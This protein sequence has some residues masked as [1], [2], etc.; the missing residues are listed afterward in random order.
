MTA[1]RDDMPAGLETLPA[2]GPARENRRTAI[3]LHPFDP[4]SVR[5]VATPSGETIEQVVRRHVADPILRAHLVAELDGIEVARD[6]WATTPV[7]EGDFLLLRV[8]PSGDDGAKILRT[9]L[10]I[11][12]V[13]LATWVT[14]GAGGAMAAQSFWA[15]A[16]AATVMVVG[17]LAINA[18]IP[19]PQPD[20]SQPSLP[21]PTYSVDG[22]RNQ[23]L[24]YRPMP[25]LFGEHRVFPPL[26]G[27]P[28]QEIVG[29]DV[30]LRYLLNLGPMPLAYDVA[31]I[32]I[33]ETPISEY[34][35][36]EYEIR[37]TP[38]DP[39]ITL[40]RDDP[41]TEAVGTLLDGAGW[42]S[43]TSQTETTELVAVFAFPQGLGQVDD[44]GRNKALSAS[45]EMRYRPTGSSEPWVYYRPTA[46]QGNSAAAA[47]GRD[48]LSWFVA[49]PDLVDWAGNMPGGTASGSH[50]VTRSD[51]GKPFRVALRAA[52]PKG[53]YDVE[54]RRVDTAQGDGKQKFDRVEWG[55]LRSI[56]A[57][58]PMPLTGYAYMAVYVKA[59]DQ[60]SGVVD[61]IN[62][63]LK[64]KAPTL[65]AAIANAAE[66][67]LSLVAASDWTAETA[68]R[69]P[70]DNTLFL[71]R[72]GHTQRPLPDARIDWPAW[73]AFW[74]WNRDNNYS[75][76]YVIDTEMTRAKAA[77]L[78]CATGRARPIWINGKLSVVIDG[79]RLDGER[80]LF[81]PRS[82]RGFRVR[83]TFPGDVH[84]L[85]INFTNR[86]QGYREDEMLVFADGYSEYGE[87]E[88]TV[89]AS[90]YE[91]LQLPGV[92]DPEIVWRLG[93]FW[94]YTALL[95]TETVE[96]DVDVESVASRIGDLVA[97][98]HDV[99]LVGLGSGRVK[100]LTTDG[101]GDVTAI[102]LD[103]A[104]DASSGHLVMEEGKDYAIRWR[105]VEEAG[106]GT[107]SYQVS[108]SASL[109]V[110]TV[111]GV[112][113]TLQLPAP[114][115][116][117][118]A[119]KVGDLVAFG[120]TGL[121]TAPLLIKRIRPSRNF[122]AMIL[123]V[124]YAPERF[125][126]DNGTVP[127]FNTRITL[128][129]A[130]KPPQPTLAE[131]YVTEDGIFVR[132]DVPE[133]YAE[134]LTGFQV[135]WR[136][137]PESGSIARFDRLPD[138]RS[139][140]RVVVLPPG[141]P[142]RTFDVEI[143]SL[144]PD[145]RAGDSLLITGL[146]ASDALAQP[147]GV[148]VT[149]AT[150]AGPDGAS[151]P[152]VTVTWTAVEDPRVADLLVYAKAQG[153]SA[154]GYRVIFSDTPRAGAGEIRGLVPGK[155][156]DFGFA[157]RDERGAMSDPLVEIANV[158]VP[159][160]LVA[161]DATG[162]TAAID[163]ARDAINDAQ[164][165]ADATLADAAGK[166]AEAAETGLQDSLLN[167]IEDP[168]GSD[169][170]VA[171][172]G[173]F[174]IGKTTGFKAMWPSLASGEQTTKVLWFPH[175]KAVKPGV[176]VQ[177]G[178]EVAVEGVTSEAILEAVWYDA[179]GSVLA[180]EAMD[181]AASGRLADVVQ[182]PALA[183]TV[184]FRLVPDASTSGQGS[185]AVS[186]PFTAFARP[187]QTTADAF[188]DPASETRSRFLSIERSMGEMAGSVRQSL[189][190]NR[191]ARA[192]ITSI[193]A[194]QVGQDSAIAA[195]K[196]EVLTTVSG[197]YV[198]SAYAIETFQ[199]E[200][201]VNQSIGSYQFAVGAITDTISGHATTTAGAV[202]D[203]E[204]G[205]AYWETLVEASGS[206]PAIAGLTAGK[207]GSAVTLGGD[208]L[209]FINF[210]GG[211]SIKAM[212]VVGGDV[213]ISNDLYVDNAIIMAAGGAV[214]GGASGYL[215]GT[216]FFLGYD[217][218]AYK[219]AVGNPAGQYMAWD[220]ATLAITGDFT[221]SFGS[222]GLLTM[223]DLGAGR[224]GFEILNSAGVEA[225]YV[226]DTGAMR[227]NGDALPTTRAGTA[228]ST[229]SPGE[230]WFD[231]S[232]DTEYRWNGSTW[233]VWGS[234]GARWTDNV[235]DRPANLVALTGSEGI[236]NSGITIGSNGLLTGAG[237]G[238]V[239]ISG[240]GYVGDL[241]AT[242][243]ANW[244][245]NVAGRPTELTDGR[246]TAGLDANGDLVR[247]ITSSRATSSDL[248][249]RTGG[250]LFNG[251]LDAT[252]GATWGDNV[253]SIPANL[254]ALTGS[255]GIQN[256]AVSIGSNGA[257]TGAGGGQVTIAGLG[258]TGALNA[259]YGATWGNNVASIPS[260]LASLTGAE[261]ILNSGISIAANGS[262]SGGGGGQVTIAGLGYTGALNANYITNTN[263]LT[264]GAGLGNTA[265]W[266]SVSGRPANL[267]SLSGGESILNSGIT[268][269]ANGA[270][271]GGGGGQVTL[272]GLG[273]GTLA[274]K[275]S[276]SDTELASGKALI[277]T[278]S[279]APT[280]TSVRMVQDTTTG[281]V[282]AD[283]G[284]SARRISQDV[285]TNT[286]GNQAINA[287][288]AG[289]YEVVAKVALENC[290]ENT[291]VGF[292]G[293]GIGYSSATANASSAAVEGQWAVI[294]SATETA[295]GSTIN[296]NVVGSSQ[297]LAEGATDGL[298]YFN[299]GGDT[300]E[301]SSDF[302]SNVS[303]KFLDGSITGGTV[304]IHLGLRV[305][306]GSGTIN[307]G[308][309]LLRVP[310]LS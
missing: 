123:G 188:Q 69:N 274:T 131:T 231:T 38:D 239:T 7:Y 9:V 96:F 214:R 285:Y 3:A 143:T 58:D 266:G 73:T 49:E 186:E 303:P 84:A 122:D 294:A 93:R 119:P 206:N 192:V 289:I 156:Y 29:D 243:G 304:Y 48:R 308:S 109:P 268:I 169:G 171:D 108:V 216:G 4:G 24:P 290:D 41:F 189:T 115:D 88:G 242:A 150:F 57:R 271:T 195:A 282:Y 249:R 163:A 162:P 193:M 79:P 178:V 307:A 52:V 158:T 152:G 245:T 306:S 232:D 155:A 283:D 309:C 264:D 279:G 253:I 68:T 10:Q 83:K 106:E 64:R 94:L 19:P 166:L 13:A 291:L 191:R 116:P 146:A 256:S 197:I 113:E 228:P 85:R 54:V 263:E 222:S 204:T 305:S 180:T 240:L 215:T 66:P 278:Q 37:A 45:V 170:W 135:R 136:Q 103:E 26:Q 117:A 89:A 141:V 255:E 124:A 149:P 272:G 270:L 18:L 142:G 167:W 220:G 173:G 17:N 262:L 248:L 76:D 130:P 139:D 176:L 20:F 40:Y 267:S 218:S 77:Q 293:S 67:D 187:G 184:R 95:Q 280:P 258:Y 23:A 223:G 288:A 298:Q 43:R 134:S 181:N 25:V 201:Q 111:A 202:A 56:S 144:G 15:G 138:L 132:F 86:E 230:W 275:S 233:D 273:A 100:S 183:A 159:N 71:Y 140:E 301:Q 297:V 61:A 14:G 30:Y 241:N 287:T 194:T 27:V 34:S 50:T 250:G 112:V 160:T 281:V 157:F 35:G 244:A 224:T 235:Y 203:I 154:A 74:I 207:D 161:N 310:R 182:A 126:A 107:G 70:A 60:L 229:P 114:V 238:Q 22:A 63:V 147:S 65:A 234:Y 101:S 227:L 251:D 196:T 286:G 284:I 165:R 212:E 265:A 28:V 59:S 80:Q 302:V 225:F 12:V 32:K 98:Q 105:F 246:I 6:S 164:G 104:G 75:V 129:R 277:Q 133:S 247:N 217:G 190:E 125:E 82:T 31:D 118:D 237:G 148:A 128:P 36:V 151:V 198:T 2:C 47:V 81:T 213:R 168:T 210:V 137:S 295:E 153:A 211:T 8:R 254:A 259:T 5:T 39:P 261:S 120:E 46:P 179:A 91:Q 174:I 1:P 121:E 127:A 226:D 185:V 177:A 145:G 16:A 21:S 90:F 260:N 55:A 208:A 99:M 199:T 78:L 11:A 102:T 292:N 269:G 221:R 110:S 200:S 300:L 42:V 92:T 219:L 51:P 276:V 209:Y 236:N 53:Q 257:L 72:G 175:E 299:D 172:D 87:V 252:L 205:A 44:K 62:L 97:V 296:T 33:G